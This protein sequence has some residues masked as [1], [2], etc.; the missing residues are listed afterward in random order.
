[1]VYAHAHKL[2]PTSCATLSS[3]LLG[4]PLPQCAATTC[5]PSL[6]DSYLLT[7]LPFASLSLRPSLDTPFNPTP[8]PT[9]SP[10]PSVYLS[11][12]FCVNVTG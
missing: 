6:Y 8:T 10:L 1:M 11:H 2:Q 7:S 3:A 9:P 5:C 4:L 12:P